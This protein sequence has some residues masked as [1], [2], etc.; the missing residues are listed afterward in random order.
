VLGPDQKITRQEALRLETMNNAYTTF[1]E[2]I[3]GSIE[4]G[5]L[6]DLVVLP[7]DI[8]TVPAKSIESMNVLMTMVGG[9]IV[10]Q[11]EDF[12]PSVTT[13]Q[14]SNPSDKLARGGSRSQQH[15]ATPPAPSREQGNWYPVKASEKGPFQR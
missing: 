9:K 8:M 3:K 1:E 4:P 12:R 6:A 2:T 15:D 5:K 13:A 10:Y 11:R 14:V 7:D